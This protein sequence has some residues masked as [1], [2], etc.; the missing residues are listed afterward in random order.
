MRKR[1]PPPHGSG[2]SRKAISCPGKRAD[3]AVRRF[4]ATLREAFRILEAEGAIHCGGR[5]GRRAAQVPGISVAA[6]HIG[7]LLQYRGACFPTSTRLAP[8]SSRPRPGWRR[9]AGRRPIWPGCRRRLTGIV[10][11][12]M[13]RAP[14]SP[15]TP[16][17]RLSRKCRAA[18]PSRS[19]WACGPASSARGT[20]PTPTATTGNRSRYLPR[21]RSGRIPGCRAHP[22]A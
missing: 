5:P 16:N 19:W 22:Q 6:R 12:P 13:T 1:V 20:G 4:A 17:P 14:P 8:S 2:R 15:P 9:K 10:S 18:R 21:S 7:L 3:G 11:R